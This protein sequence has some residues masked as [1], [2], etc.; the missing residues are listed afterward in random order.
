MRVFRGVVA[1]AV[2]LCLSAAVQA[3]QPWSLFG[4]AEF[5]RVGDRGNQWAIELSSIGASFSGIAFEPRKDTT[6]A[7]LRQLSASYLI[8]EG[9]FG[10]GSPRFQIALDTDGDGDFNG[11]V[12]LYL[13]TP[14][15]FADDTEDWQS[16]GNLL[17]SED[18][19]FDLTQFGGPFYG[20]Y[21]DALAL[22]GDAEVLEISLVVDAGWKFPETGQVIL[23]DNVR[24]DNF[25]LNAQ[26]AAKK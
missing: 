14:P 26:G 6:F 22:V 9:A 5:V 17:A 11:N 8:E 21:E 15:N 16:T 19:R 4:D 13:G 23:V 3:A 2:L 1:A 18:L 25:N 20:G 7:D 10:G 24:V 12:F